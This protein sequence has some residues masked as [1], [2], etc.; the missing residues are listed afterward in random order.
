MEA[1]KF[2]KDWERC[3]AVDRT[4]PAQVLKYYNWKFTEEPDHS[5]ADPSWDIEFQDGSK[6][7]IGNPNGSYF[8]P[9]VIPL[10]TEDQM[11]KLRRRIEDRLRKD[12]SF[13]EE[14]AKI[15]V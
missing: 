14:V 12:E 13:L 15:F 3:Y 11:K 1:I 6:A 5:S 7:H 4:C 2:L 8:D 9:F 10:L